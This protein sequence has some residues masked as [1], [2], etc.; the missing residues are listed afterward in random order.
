MKFKHIE[1]VS[2]SSHDV[3]SSYMA[4]EEESTINLDLYQG[5]ENSKILGFEQMQKNINRQQ[6]NEVEN[7]YI[8]YQESIVTEQ[9]DINLQKESINIDSIHSNITSDTMNAT[10]S[11]KD[12]RGQA[13][14]FHSQ[15]IGNPMPKRII[16]SGSISPNP[17][18][19][20]VMGVGGGG[21]N[22]V[23]KMIQQNVKNV[24]IV[25]TN[26]DAQTLE[27]C[28]APQILPL[29]YQVTKGLGTGGNPL[30]GAE[31]AREVRKDIYEFIKDYDM[32]FLAAGLGGG[33]GT[34]STPVIAEIAK[35][36]GVLSLAV[37][38]MPFSHEGS[39]HISIA[40]YGLKELE[41]VVDALLVIPN[42][43]ITNNDFTSSDISLGEGFK[44]VDDVLTN[45]VRSI[46]EIITV[47]SYFNID[48]ADIKNCLSGAGRIAVGFGSSNTEERKHGNAHRAI[49]VALRN[50][51]ISH[52]NIEIIGSANHIIANTIAGLDVSINDYNAI[53]DLIASR[54]N[55]D[56]KHAFK[57]G[58][59]LDENLGKGVQ[60]TIIASHKPLSQN[61]QCLQK[62]SS[63]STPLSNDTVSTNYFSNSK[64]V[65]SKSSDIEENSREIIKVNSDFVSGDIFDKLINS[66]NSN[67]SDV[68][69]EDME[70]DAYNTPAINRLLNKKDELDD[71]QQHTITPQVKK[72]KAD[73]LVSDHVY[74]YFYNR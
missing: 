72:T 43:N 17:T 8:A 2:S 18:R 27:S 20:C 49:E 50:T 35:E 7:D 58:F 62:N 23:N 4:D 46:S 42:D 25:A 6:D 26:T 5:K 24:D 44:I 12:T 32:V 9:N 11:T 68:I 73:L 56:G 66:G 14:I 13:N 52:E 74:D 57:H 31:A 34:G 65:Q 70:E 37:V 28:L 41:S 40:E 15:T 71:S 45:T 10:N 63:L 19:I 54:V 60:V 53:S 64:N 22:A 55:G 38:T 39:E 67:E 21:V 30:R 1:G 36:A 69:L 16:G 33:T 51:I 29:G 61:I 48:F 59:R 3:S 47:P